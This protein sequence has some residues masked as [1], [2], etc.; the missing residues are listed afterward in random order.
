MRISGGIARGFSLKN[1]KNSDTRP[2]TDAARQA[3]FSSLADTI[4][5]AKVLD[6]FAGTGSYGLESLSRGATSAEFVEFS[7]KEISFLKD[8]VLG[9]KKYLPN[10]QTKIHTCDAFKFSSTEDFDIIFADPPYD[11]L[12]EKA[13]YVLDI[14]HRNSNENTLIILEAP[15][16]FDIPENAPFEIIKRL[17]K[18]S[19][20]KPTQLIMRAIF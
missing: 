4:V 15:F 7:K 11:F 16:E 6:I 1:Q 10:A 12:R 20:G 8:N 18:K 14:L 5:N 17:G 3:I 19:K 2:A 13:Q 9:I